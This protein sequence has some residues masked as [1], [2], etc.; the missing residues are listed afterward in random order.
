MKIPK[1]V[2]SIL[3]N[4]FNGCAGIDHYYFYSETPPAL[5]ANSVFKEIKNLAKFMFLK[6][7]WKRIKLQISGVS[8]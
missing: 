4:A 7:V 5:G 2:S 1:N 8:L 6:A 3:G